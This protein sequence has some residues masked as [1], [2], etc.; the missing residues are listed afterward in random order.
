MHH[1]MSSDLFSVKIYTFSPMLNPILN[2]KIKLKSILN[3][4]SLDTCFFT[5]I[6][7]KTFVNK[8]PVI[9]N[10][11]PLPSASS[12]PASLAGVVSLM[13]ALSSG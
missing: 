13:K 3:Q 11:P 5:K 4:V 7:Y 12:V 2:S 10:C 1:L 6:S 8:A 9:L